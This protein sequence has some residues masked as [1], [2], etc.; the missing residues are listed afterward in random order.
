[1][2]KTLTDDINF[3]NT[4]VRVAE[5]FEELKLSETTYLEAVYELKEIARQENINS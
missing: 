4:F 2:G 5:N 3:I 1:M